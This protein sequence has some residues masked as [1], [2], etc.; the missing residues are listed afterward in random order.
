LDETFEPPADVAALL[1]EQRSVQTVRVQIPH[2]AR[3]AADVYA[4]QVRFVQDDEL[5][6]TLDLDLLPPVERRVGLL[7]LVAG[8]DARVLSPA[9]LI[10]AGPKVAAGLL[11]HHRGN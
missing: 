10:A 1:E 7:T 8:V 2:A 5:T 6:V 4:E 9:P 3:W 11:E